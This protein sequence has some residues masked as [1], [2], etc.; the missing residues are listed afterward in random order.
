MFCPVDG[1]KLPDGAVFCPY[2][3]TNLSK[4]NNNP[5]TDDTKKHGKCLF[6]V[7]RKKNI[8]YGIAA[9]IK[10]Y[11]DGNLVKKLS[12]G[13]YFSTI[14]DNGRHRLSCEY[15]ITRKSFEF[16][17]DDNEI[18]YLLEMPFNIDPR[19]TFVV[20]KVKETQPGTYKG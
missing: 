12:N 18:A 15:Y 20:N 14:L 17:G 1:Q 16:T 3:G 6:S 10:I 9:G 7:E 13:E 11:I 5:N 8:W 4:L 2:C 19:E